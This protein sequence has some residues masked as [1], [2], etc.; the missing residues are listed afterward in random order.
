MAKNVAGRKTSKSAELS[1]A[2]RFT[3]YVLLRKGSEERGRGREVDA[4]RS[5]RG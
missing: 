3:L 1:V 2:S 4:G 5:K